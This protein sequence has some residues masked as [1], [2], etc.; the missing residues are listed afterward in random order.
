MLVVTDKLWAQLI[1]PRVL[2][3]VWLLIGSPILKLARRGGEL[4]KARF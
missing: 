1:A 4:D 2:K 3:L